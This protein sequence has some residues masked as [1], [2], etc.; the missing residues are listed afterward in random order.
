MDHAIDIGST[1]VK[2]AEHGRA[3]DRLPRDYDAGIEAQVGGAIDAIRGRDP[4]ARFRICSS[5]N[6][7]LRVGILCLTTRFSGRVAANLASAAGANVV[8]MRSLSNG[9]AAPSEAVDALVLVG[10][11]DGPD[12]EPLERHLDTHTP[13]LNG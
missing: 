5:A 6:G 11:T 1:I 7:G 12:S 4:E 13:R 2:I 3:Q 9:E 8:F 10:G